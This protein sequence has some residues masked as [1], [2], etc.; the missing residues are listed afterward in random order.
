MLRA[1]FTGQPEHVINF[2]FRAEEVREIM[3]ALGYRTFDEMIGSMQKRS[4]S[5]R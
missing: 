2:F 1:R 4:T 3:A 5:R